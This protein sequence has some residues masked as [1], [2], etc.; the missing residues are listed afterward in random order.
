MYLNLILCFVAHFNIIIKFILMS[1][2]VFSGFTL[3]RTMAMSA[4]KFETLI[5]TEPS[6]FVYHVEINRPEKRNAMN[7]TF[8]RL[9]YSVYSVFHL[10]V[11]LS[12]CL[13][14]S[15]DRFSWFC[16]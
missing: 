1:N 13:T 6:E 7:M 11:K 12:G 3:K 9:K 2:F 10:L 15:F 8:W 16:G 5:V 4:Y 14:S